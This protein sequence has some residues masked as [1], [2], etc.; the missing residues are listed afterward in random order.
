MFLGVG[1][2]LDGW[3]ADFSTVTLRL[4]DNPLADF[5]ELPPAMSD[6]RYSNI[7]VGVL[8]GALEMVRAA[9]EGAA[10]VRHV[11]ARHAKARTEPRGFRSLQAYVE[12]PRSQ[13]RKA[14]CCRC[15]FTCIASRHAHN[16]GYHRR[17][18]CAPR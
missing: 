18:P 16:N 3:S 12:N 10:A 5:V 2:A 13:A 11:V 15:R 4:A 9:R 1:A 6:L 8:R 14:F 17:S 7:L